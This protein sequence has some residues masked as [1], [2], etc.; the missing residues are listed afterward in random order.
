MP[1]VKVSTKGQIVIPRE[2]REAIGIRPNGRVY[3]EKTGDYAVIRPAPDAIRELRGILKGVPSMSKELLE[4][5]QKEI[6][7][8]EKLFT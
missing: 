4:E 1:V 2:I 7:E 8:D 6:K 5:H 3:L